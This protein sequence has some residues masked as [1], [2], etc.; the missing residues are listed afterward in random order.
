[1]AIL[2]TDAQ[3]TG[4]RWLSPERESIEAKEQ[5]INISPHY[6]NSMKMDLLKSSQPLLVNTTEQSSISEEWNENAQIYIPTESVLHS[7]VAPMKWIV[8]SFCIEV[9][10]KARKAPHE[11]QCTEQEK[12]YML[13]KRNRSDDCSWVLESVMKSKSTVDKWN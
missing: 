13:A 8:F 11:K 10:A 12:K 6:W 5:D 9:K 1:M 4:E 7:P 2:F 3:Q